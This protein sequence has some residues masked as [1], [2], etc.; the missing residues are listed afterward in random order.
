[1]AYEFVGLLSD[2]RYAL[3]PAVATSSST[4]EASGSPSIAQASICREVGGGGAS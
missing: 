1:M 2:L 4:A 3:D